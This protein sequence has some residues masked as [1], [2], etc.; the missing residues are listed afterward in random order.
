MNVIKLFV[1]NMEGE[2]LVHVRSAS[3]RMSRS[4]RELWTNT[5]GIG[6]ALTD[7]GVG[8]G[9]HVL[10]LCSSRIEAVEV[11]LATINIGAVEAPLNPLLGTGQIA[12]V[13]SSIRPR[14]C[15]FEEPPED[16]IIRALREIGCALVSLS[17]ARAGRDGEWLSYRMLIGTPGPQPVFTRFRDTHPALLIHSSGS[18]GRLKAICLS[19]GMLFRFFEYHDFLYSQYS[20]SPDSLGATSAILTGL[21]LTH[22]AGLATCL[23]GLMSSRRTFLLSFFLPEL[24]LR[25]VEEGRCT[26]IMLV[27]SLYRSLLREPYLQQMDRSALRFCITGGE[28]CPPELAR[29]IEAAFGVPLVNVYSMTECMSGLGHLRHDLHGRRIKPG[30]CGRQ[31]FGDSRLF[32]EDGREDLS[33]GELWVRNATV[34]PCYRDEALN[35]ARFVRGW[36]RTGDLFYRDAE[37]DYFHRG[38]VDDMFICNGKNIYPLEIELVLMQHPCVESACAVAVTSASKGTIPAALIVA[39]QSLSAAAVQ[40]FAMRHG[41]AHAVPQVVTFVDELPR[42]GPGKLDRRRAAQIAQERFLPES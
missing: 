36:F 15:F 23:Q 38:R 37:G 21:P 26:F 7:L 34:Q 10:I 42:L 1:N 8:E 2:A 25:L 30:S 28:A 6:P 27:P 18:S 20:E 17:E 16:S 5:A 24:Y 35:E 40:E 33:S 22:L 32:D 19:H 29:Q 4:A 3:V 31:L 13:I 9:D 12:S 39:R 41:P 11:I 14:C